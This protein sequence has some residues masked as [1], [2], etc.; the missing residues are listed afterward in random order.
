MFYDDPYFGMNIDRR[1]TQ[2]HL[3]SAPGRMTMMRDATPASND[4]KSEKD[5]NVKKR[6]SSHDVESH[7][8]V[9]SERGGVP[10]VVST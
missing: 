8:K 9:A 4:K 3:E 5:D 7:E 6:S 2:R 10:W 1:R